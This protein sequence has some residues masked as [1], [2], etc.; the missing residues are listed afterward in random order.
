MFNDVSYLPVVQGTNVSYLPTIQGPPMPIYLSAADIADSSTVFQPGEGAPQ[1]TNEFMYYLRDTL[2]RASG[3]LLRVSGNADYNI[4]LRD[5]RQL[6][7]EISQLHLHYAHLVWIINTVFNTSTPR[8]RTANVWYDAALAREH[9]R[10]RRAF[11]T[12][13]TTQQQ[14]SIAWQPA[15]GAHR[16][17]IHFQGI[18]LAYHIWIGVLGDDDI[19]AIKSH[20]LCHAFLEDLYYIIVVYDANHFVRAPGTALPFFTMRLQQNGIV[21]AH[22]GPSD[23]FNYPFCRVPFFPGASFPCLQNYEYDRTKYY[24]LVTHDSRAQVFT[25]QKDCDLFLSVHMFATVEKR[26][27]LYSLG[28]AIAQWCLAHCHPLPERRSM[29]TKPS[30]RTPYDLTTYNH[31]VQQSRY[32][33]GPACEH[34]AAVITLSK[35]GP[36]GLIGGTAAPTSRVSHARTAAPATISRSRATAAPYPPVSSSKIAL[37]RVVAPT[38][39]VT[40]V[41]PRQY[42]GKTPPLAAAASVSGGGSAASAAP[43]NAAALG[44]GTAAPRPFLVTSQ[45]EI[46][47]DVADAEAAAAKKKDIVLKIVPDLTAAI[48]WHA[49]HSLHPEYCNR[50]RST[51]TSTFTTPPLDLYDAVGF[52][53]N[54]PGIK[55]KS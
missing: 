44:S 29:R 48:A 55:S 53:Q 2:S 36:A 42:I 45:G 19:V 6:L 41:A 4:L 22:D 28:A 24:Y 49:S 40:A 12:A 54:P 21:D 30:I 47:G 51:S 1:Y 43:A 27:G 17:G 31:G 26:S 35:G 50:N 11:P 25:E 23:H 33:D 52:T 9:A 10:V 15:L 14:F 39:E 34:E 7:H 3:E 46:F 8:F 16:Q 18:H 5:H 13:P 38:A 37:Q 32:P 20:S